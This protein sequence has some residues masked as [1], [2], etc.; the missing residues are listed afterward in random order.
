MSRATAHQFAPVPGAPESPDLHRDL[1]D[2]LLRGWCLAAVVP[3]VLDAVERDPLSSA[4]R[5]RGDLLRGLMEVPNSFWRRFPRLSDRYRAAIRA[6]A[7]VRRF[8]PLE[9]RMEFWSELR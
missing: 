9:E 1:L 5:F 7:A 4:G 2:A 8:L 6:G 3:L